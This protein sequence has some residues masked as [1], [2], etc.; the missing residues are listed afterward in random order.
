VEGGKKDGGAYL[1]LYGER[2][3]IWG[4]VKKPGKGKESEGGGNVRAARKEGGE[5][6]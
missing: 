5:K 6:K 3:R 2:P 1:N 4:K